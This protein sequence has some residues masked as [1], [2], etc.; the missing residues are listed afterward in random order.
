VPFPGE[1]FGPHGY[2]LQYQAQ[3]LMVTMAIPLAAAG[4]PVAD[5]VSALK[6]L[7]VSQY[8]DGQLINLLDYSNNP[9]SPDDRGG[10]LFRYLHSSAPEG[11][12]IV[13]TRDNGSGHFE[14][15]YDTTSVRAEWFGADCTGQRPAHKEIQLAIDYAL[16]HHVE[17]VALRDGTFV[18][19]DAPTA[20]IRGGAR[21][22][23]GVLGR[24]RPL[25][26]GRWYPRPPDAG[27]F[28]P[29]TLVVARF[30]DRPAIAIQGARYSAV[31]NLT[32]RGATLHHVRQEVFVGEFT[33]NYIGRLQRSPL[34]PHAYVRQTQAVLPRGGIRVIPRMQVAA[35]SGVSRPVVSK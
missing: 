2:C 6:A 4:V 1:T 19:D 32:L 35:L 15:L 13:F 30:K 26:R 3:R 17:E 23:H 27:R 10:G 29:G 20:G 12:G 7:D 34:T 28:S 25:P 11:H 8:Q 31:K 24:R 5:T 9:A 16:Q 22:Q 14:R 33:T 18:I 21:I